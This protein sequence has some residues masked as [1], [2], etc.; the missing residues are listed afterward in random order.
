VKIVD[1]E[2]IQLVKESE[3]PH[4]NAKQSRSRR[5]ASL[6]RVRTDDGIDGLGEAWCDA[7]LAEGVVLGKLRPLVL[8]EDPFNVEGIWRRAFDGTAMY[9]PKG[10]VV[11]GLSGIDMACW[12]IMG[13]ALGVPVCKLIGGL[14]RASIQAYA[15]DLHWQEDPADMARLAASFV[16]RGFRSVK[17]HVGVDPVDDVRRVRAL[18]EA[19]GPDIGLMV[20]INTGFD[21]PTAIRFGRRIAEYDISWYEEPLSPVDLDGLAIVR[22][23]TGIPI[24]TGENEYTRWGFREMF[25]KGGVDVAMPDMARTGGITEMKK[26]CAVAEAFGVVV[27]P[28]NYSSGVCSA[29]TLQ[30][31][32]ATP[33]TGPLEWDTV[34]SSIVAELFVEPPVV[35]DGYVQVPQLPGLGVHLPDEVRARYAM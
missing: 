10:A 4:R 7:P 35:K 22:A 20:D 8:G 15:S 29:A 30:V 21:R 3:H 17:T 1:V 13:K 33:G 14:T 25:Q 2:L 18:R 31:M 19:I 6:V 32:A 5:V 24:A 12:D 23:S 16:E 34:D 9:D 27:S 28:H 26:I 11:A